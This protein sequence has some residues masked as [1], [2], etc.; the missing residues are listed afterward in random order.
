MS[1]IM[2]YGVV[3]FTNIIQAITGFA[4]TMLAM[5]LS[6]KLIGMDPA[7]IALNAVATAASIYIVGKDYKKVNREVLKHALIWMTIGTILSMVVYR[8]INTTLLLYMY[9][10]VIIVIALRKLFAKT[11]VSIQDKFMNIILILAGVLHGLFASGGPFLVIYLT[12]KIKDKYEFRAT[13]SAIWIVLGVVFAVQNLEYTTIS[14]IRISFISMVPL[15][16][17]VLIGDWILKRITQEKFMKITYVL[18]LLSGFSV[19]I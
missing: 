3:F 6:I 8:T 7:R 12:D 18:L 2:Y 14:N 19:Y 4:G 1:E 16:G 17:G 11:E 15:V 10:V 5:P 9:G 13:V